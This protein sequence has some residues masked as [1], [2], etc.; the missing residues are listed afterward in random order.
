MDIK[1]VS[2]RKLTGIIMNRIKKVLLVIFLLVF[3]GVTPGQD[4]SNS[5][6]IETSVAKLQQKV[7]LSD[8]QASEIKTLLNRNAE[9]LKNNSR[10]EQTLRTLKSDVEKVLDARQ[11]AKYSI[12]QNDWWNTLVRDL[13]PG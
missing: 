12:I 9:D 11:K 5:D 3:A 1:E 10:R 4:K 7:L 8:R 2:L 13:S 6:V